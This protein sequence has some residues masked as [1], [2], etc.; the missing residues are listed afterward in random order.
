MSEISNVNSFEGGLTPDIHPLSIQP[1]AMTDA[2]NLEIITDGPDQNILQNIRST[3]FTCEFPTYSERKIP[4]IPLGSATLNSIAYILVGAFDK[5]GELI[6]GGVG[7]FPSP[8]WTDLNDPTKGTSRMENKFSF[9]HNFKASATS[10]GVDPF[11]SSQFDFTP[12]RHIDIVLQSVYDGSVNILY[13]DGLSQAKIINSRFSFDYFNREAKIAKRSSFTRE[14]NIYSD[15]D[16]DAI[17]LVQNGNYPVEVKHPDTIRGEGFSVED[18]G[19]L[20]GGGYRYFIKYATQEG[21]TTDVIYESPLIP[22]SGNG[23]GLDKEQFSNKRVKF[24]LSA[25]DLSYAGVVLYFAHS[26]GLTNPP[27][28]EIFKI[29]YLFK[30]SESTL[31]ITHSGHEKV[32]PVDATELSASFSAIET[33]ASMTTVNDRLVLAGV[34]SSLDDKTIRILAGAASKVTLWEKTENLTTS[35]ADPEVAAKKVGYWKGEVYE[36]AGVFIIEGKGLSPAFPLRGMD[37][38]YGVQA[39]PLFNASTYLTA[40]IED[41]GFSNTHLIN[42][43]GLFRFSAQGPIFTPGPGDGTRHVTYV[44][45]DTSSFKSDAALQKIISGFFIVRRKRNKNVLLQGMAVPTLKVPARRPTTVYSGIDGWAHVLDAMKVYLNYFKPSSPWLGLNFKY[46]SFKS[47]RVHSTAFNT[48]FDTVFLPQA[49]QQI[50]VATEDHVWSVTGDIGQSSA[51]KYGE[52]IDDDGKPIGK[53][54]FAILSIE[55]DING[56]SISSLLSGLTPKIEVQEPRYDR[57]PLGFAVSN[58]P[59]DKPDRFST[60]ANKVVYTAEQV[61]MDTPWIAVD[62]ASALTTII[63]S[64]TK[65]FSKN[66]FSA[67]TDRCYGC[68]S[69]SD[70]GTEVDPVDNS[71]TTYTPPYFVFGGFNYTTRIK[72]IE[73][74]SDSAKTNSDNPSTAR[75]SFYPYSVL[76]QK[77]STYIG[78]EVD[79]RTNTDFRARLPLFFYTPSVITDIT[80]LANASKIYAPQT[81]NVLYLNTGHLTNIYGSSLGRW[82]QA[83]IRKLYMFDSEA[84]YSAA[85]PRI[86]KEIL[87]KNSI[88]KVFRGDTFITTALKKTSY[89]HGIASAPAATEGDAAVFGT[90]LHK[91]YAHSGKL[92]D[93]PEPE[94]KDEGR[95]LFASGEVVQIVSFSN[96]NADIRSKAPLSDEDK[97]LKRLPRSF[98]PVDKDVF[99]DGRPDSSSYNFGYSSDNYPIEYF[100]LSESAPF[101]STQFPN[102]VMLSEKSQAQAFVNAFRNFRGF[103]FRDYGVSLGP[104][105]KVI[106]IKGLLLTIHPAGVLGI[107]IDE[108]TLVSEGTSVVVNTAQA[109]NPEAEPISIMYG[110]IHPESI[111][112]TTDTI[113]GVD[114]SRDAVWV[115]AGASLEIISQYSVTTVLARFRQEIS[116][117]LFPEA[118]QGV[119]YRPR[120]YSTFNRANQALCVTYIAEHPDTGRQHHIGALVYN[121]ILQKWTTRLTEGAKFVYPISSSMYV[122]GFS[123]IG[124]IWKVDAGKRTDGTFSRGVYFGKAATYELEFIINKEASLE[125]VLDNIQLICNKFVPDTVVYTTTTDVNDA[126]SDIWSNQKEVST[127]SQKIITRNNSPRKANRL[128]I[129]DEN[130]YYKNSGL[131]IEVGKVGYTKRAARGNRR[132]RDKYIKVRFIYSGDHDLAIQGILSTLSLSYS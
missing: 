24:H 116:F 18:G 120:V 56:A 9:L 60:V 110:S 4:F 104:I 94:R 37:N 68:M 52:T 15:K 50:R 49:T 86:S 74:L 59:V 121:M 124:S 70:G 71:T 102:R 3:E 16:W 113:A 99:S 73:L 79:V 130:A 25:L 98:Y 36:Y 92:E 85:T 87:N 42:S 20:R 53:F 91:R 61:T 128:G 30:Y 2:L 34:S 107:G 80:T 32:I 33:I 96:V 27:T 93:I 28:T 112:H 106:S 19:Q 75:S 55:L 105:I 13:T 51:G 62:S 97:S 77:Y 131:Y 14:S 90:G 88:I 72:I 12:T 127:L 101:L 29:N 21:N 123:E 81:P 83:D 122:T 100:R 76:T 115:F 48:D 95:N 118:I 47:D 46:T 17:A 11:I 44:E 1:N 117:G 84:G 111:V 41:D 82:S 103:N 114:Y 65:A 31:I 126:A 89:K 109:L 10:E 38:F 7:T 57:S 108:K 67:S 66:S 132:I 43:K 8:N 63:P 54:H 5:D 39:S 129:L 64:G 40:K 6:V 22:I 35:Y 23:F 58:T 45:A 119:V 26:D 69:N 78:V 125:K